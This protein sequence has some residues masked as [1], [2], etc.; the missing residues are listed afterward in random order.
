MLAP[1]E[2]YDAG[3]HAAALAGDR[4]ELTPEEAQRL[5]NRLRKEK[6]ARNERIESTRKAIE[7]NA[8]AAGRPLK[9]PRG[10]KGE[11][12]EKDQALR[13]L[14]GNK[15]RLQPM[16]AT[17][18]ALT[19]RDCRV[20]VLL[21]RAKARTTRAARAA[22]APPRARTARRRQCR[23][24][25]RASSCRRAQC[26]AELMLHDWTMTLCY[27]EGRSGT[28]TWWRGR[29][30]AQQGAASWGGRR[31]GAQKKARAK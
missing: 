25:G 22:R 16:M 23:P 3:R 15:V 19:H 17:C 5:H 26:T 28:N 1:E 2:I 8:E 11:S 31:R 24:Q 7:L 13:K 18:V 27:T 30:W 29:S 12:Q 9:A 21:A 20:S 10:K 4:S 6:R 14:L